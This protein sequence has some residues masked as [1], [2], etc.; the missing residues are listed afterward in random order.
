MSI[1]FGEILVILLICFLVVGPND[2]PKVARGI[3]KFVK[4]T[5]IA[6]RDI[7]KT[8]EDELELDEV[9]KSSEQFKKVNS[10]FEKVQQ[11]VLKHASEAENPNA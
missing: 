3:A 5:R 11:D 8:F 7:S 1:G 4:K 10:E 2:L 9:K 6:M